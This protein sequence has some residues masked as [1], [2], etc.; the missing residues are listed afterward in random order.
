LTVKR[1]GVILHIGKKNSFLCRDDVLNFLAP[2]ASVDNLN[3]GR[4][5]TYNDAGVSVEAGN[6]L[7]EMIKPAV[8]STRR[9]GADAEIGGFGGLFDLKATG[10]KD[11][12][13]VSGTDGVGT[14]LRI[15]VDAGIHEFVGLS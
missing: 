7:V 4:A 15:A 14:K 3:T 2:R 9:P 8:R 11:P 5:L 12:I 1:L 10:Y 6:T 13:L